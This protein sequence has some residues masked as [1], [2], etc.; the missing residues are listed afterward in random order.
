LIA[1]GDKDSSN[2]EEGDNGGRDGVG[3]SNDGDVGRDGGDAGLL[4]DTSLSRDDSSPGNKVL[5]Q[6]DSG[7]F[8]IFAFNKL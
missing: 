7:K 3:A 5:L 2:G 8:E 1:T 6:T 4:N